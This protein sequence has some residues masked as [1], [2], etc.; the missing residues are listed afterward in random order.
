[1]TSLEAYVNLEVPQTSAESGGAGEDGAGFTRSA[2]FP[3]QVPAQ[4]P[5]LP[6]DDERIS[7]P[8]IARMDLRTP[9]ISGEFPGRWPAGEVP[10]IGPRQTIV[11]CLTLADSPADYT[12]IR[13]T[14]VYEDDSGWI[15]TVNAVHLP[16]EVSWGR[17]NAESLPGDHEF[18]GMILRLPVGSCVKVRDG[19]VVEISQA[20]EA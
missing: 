2:D 5:R 20:G 6:S 15:V 3:A 9:P 4:S 13:R 19:A 1:M 10:P 17:L 14:P 16:A 7:A 18:W 8:L 12:L 11:V